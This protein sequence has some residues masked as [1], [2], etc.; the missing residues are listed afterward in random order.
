MSLSFEKLLSR[1]GYLVYKTSGVSMEPMLRQNRDTVGIRI[2][3]SR[4]KK[5]R[6]CAL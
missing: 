6:R 5:I 3:L 4:L 2:P 1:D